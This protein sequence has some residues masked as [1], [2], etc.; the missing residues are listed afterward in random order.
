MCI[1]DSP[2]A[3]SQILE[4]LVNAI[5]SVV[6]AGYL[7]QLGFKATLIY[8]ES[9]YAEAYGA[10]GG[11]LGTGMGAAAALLFVLFLYLMYRPALRRRVR[12][13]K[14]RRRESYGSLTGIFICTVIP[15]ILSTTIYL[16]LIHI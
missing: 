13:D 2:T 6:A 16:S 15:V 11:T 10:A 1:R 14:T 8:D 7:F 3:V 9:G 4:Q 12:R 5:I